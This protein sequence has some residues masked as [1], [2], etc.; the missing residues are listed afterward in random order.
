MINRSISP[1]W[2]VVAGAI[3]AALGAG[4]IMVYT[5]GL[6]SVPMGDEFGWSREVLS[7][8]MT[9]FLIGSGLG[10]VALGWLISRYGIRLPSAL[11]AGLFGL[12]FAG[13]AIM[14]QQ[15]VMFIFVFLL[16]GICGA[17]CTA[18]PYAVA[19]SGFFD[20]RR[21][22]A[23][24]IVVA[25][26][27]VG[28]TLAPRIAQ[29]LLSG[30][31]WRAGF[32]VI[33]VAAG[34]V[35]VAGLTLLV[36]TPDG[37]VDRIGTSGGRKRAASTPTFLALYVRNRYFWS[38]A[39]PILAV[40]IAAFGGMTS[41]VRLFRDHEIDAATIAGALSF[42]GFCS[43]LGR[44]AVGYLL[45]KVF[46]PFMCAITFVVAAAGLFLLV[47]A[48]GSVAAYVGSAMVAV[49]LGAEADLISFLV[50]RYF[51][52]SDYSRV[53][54]V[55]WVVWAWGGG[56]GTYLAEKSHG[57]FGSYQPAFYLFAAMLALGALVICR[58]GPYRNS[59]V[60]AGASDIT[61]AENAVA[62]PA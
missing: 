57:T 58:I 19:I 23:L 56:V 11:L 4:P 18:L 3:C 24:G 52:L 25:G 12:L 40:S 31:G 20:A 7:A 60:P 59:V 26:N 49:A 53:L 5:Y 35:S 13:V 14:P 15:P 2:T 55:M 29:Y 47:G 10:A 51:R 22:L 45:D 1:Q 30:Y 34:L 37:V 38:I 39:I 50:S 54:G 62:R 36:R 42:A 46:A 9:S 43:W 21:G 44:V 16:I 17:A 32:L 27:G 61:A 8:N 6:L 41:L 48:H 28:A 33:G